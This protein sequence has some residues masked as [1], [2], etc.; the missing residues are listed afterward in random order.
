MT[1]TGK[2]KA[3]SGGMT[4]LNRLYSLMQGQTLGPNFRCYVNSV[5][6]KRL[7]SRRVR[8]RS[9]RAGHGPE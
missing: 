1:G 7:V 8:G 2:P 5:I 9:L 6:H 3:F 4:Q